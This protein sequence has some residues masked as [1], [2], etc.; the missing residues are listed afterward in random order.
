[1]YRLALVLALLVMLAGC[2][3]SSDE[4]SDSPAPPAVSQGAAT[5]VADKGGDSGSASSGDAETKKKKKTNGD[6]GD[7]KPADKDEGEKSASD[8][9]PE[10]LDEAIDEAS[11]EAINKLIRA[12][13]VGT[14]EIYDL[15]LAQLKVAKGG[16]DVNVFVTQAS[17]CKA[18]AR[19]EPV[20]AQ[21]IQKAAPVVKSVSFEVAG[22]GKELGY[23]VLGCKRPAV[24]SG[25][26]TVV[27]QREGV[28]GPI[29]T[30]EFRIRGKRWAIEYEN[31]SSFLAVLVLTEGENKNEPIGSKKREVG[32]KV[33]NSGPGTYKLQ[34]QG[35]GFWSVRVK[36][37][38]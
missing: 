15:D 20:M 9:Q 6:K 3:G 13:V 23:Y 30:K 29:M 32:R 35:G 8:D 4:N 17:A 37:I 26:G 33:Y 5:E 11:P 24:P 16:R 7:D 12:A 10:S 21:R 38:R 1:M 36:D 2:G 31:G 14:L 34:I 25:P 28:G 18:V 19:D 22:T 27:L